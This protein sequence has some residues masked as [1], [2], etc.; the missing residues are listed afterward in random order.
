MTSY[1]YTLSSEEHPPSTLVDNGRK[2]EA[3]GFDF[4][5]ISDHFHPWVS[6]QGHSPFVWS[7][8]GAI[9][10]S[11]DRIAVGVGVNCPTTRTHPAIVAHAAATT[12]LLFG[13]RF[14]LGVGTGEA[15]N[16]HIVAGR[17]PPPEVRLD[18]LEEAIEIMRALWS[19]DTVDH[20]GRFYEVDNARLFDPPAATIPVIV[21]AFGPKAAAVA[22]R[23]GDGYWG[24]SPTK[25]IV[26]RFTEAGGTGPRYAQID[27]CRA[28]EAAAARR[29]VHK[30]WP[31]GAVK[32]QLSQD[33]PTWTHFEEAAGMVTED[34]A[35]ASVPCGPD[36]GPVVESVRTYLDAGYDHLH[37]HQIGPDQDGFFEFWSS[38]LRPALDALAT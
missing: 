12:S 24:T 26:E 34:D 3:A 6:A 38:E 23:V 21:S 19:G 18:M 15:L 14:F 2:A 32:G 10:A 31:N 20:R 36:V 4:V 16:E 17:W 1:G 11:T 9:A 8:L 13:D 33:L 30:I 37:F 35:T 22:A 28:D 7:V 25:E 27:L 5:T 29:T